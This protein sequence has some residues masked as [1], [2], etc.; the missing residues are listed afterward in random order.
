[1]GIK[2]ERSLITSKALEMFNICFFSPCAEW[3]FVI[4]TRKLIQ[5][6]FQNHISAIG[7]GT[8]IQPQEFEAC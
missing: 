1:M 7:M 3:G 4:K 5:V 6:K 8:V 2:K